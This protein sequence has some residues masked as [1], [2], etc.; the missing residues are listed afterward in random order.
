MNKEEVK[1]RELVQ[2]MQHDGV[3]GMKAFYALYSGYLTAVC[4]R[5][6]PDK[7]DVKDVLQE[8]FINI[9]NAVARFQYKGV[10]SLKAWTTRIIVNEALKH[11]KEKEK[12][13]TTSIFHSDIE[14]I[15]DEQEPDFDA[16]P[17]SEII[18]MIQELPAGY[19]TVF[20]LYVF[21]QK[22]HKEIATLLGIGENSSASQFHRAKA[23][24][25]K[26]I[27]IVRANNKS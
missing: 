17:P 25:V 18:Q 6:I 22:S 1:E 4:M 9:Y 21:E 24:L 3:R 7:D 11:L 5:Y 23:L 27:N 13:K 26:K 2:M 10:G 19:R 20:N 14:A 16:I 12:L 8:G 15:E